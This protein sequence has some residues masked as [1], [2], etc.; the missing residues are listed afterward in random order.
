MGSG[1]L[2]LLAEVRRSAGCGPSL[3]AVGFGWA[4]PRHSWL[5]ALGAVPRHSW[6]GACRWWWLVVPRHSWLRVLGAVP[7]HSWLGSAGCG[8]GRFRGVWWGVSRVACVC[9]AAR[10]GLCAVCVWQ[11]CGCGCVFRVCW[12]VCGGAGR[13]VSLAGACWWCLCGWGCGWCVGGPSPLLA[14][15][16]ACVSPPLLAGLHRRWWWALLATPG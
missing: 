1:P 3:P 12:R 8:G 9:G 13:F 11:W 14:E 2:P 5:R 15:V 7:R 10:A 16:P 4:F 6:L